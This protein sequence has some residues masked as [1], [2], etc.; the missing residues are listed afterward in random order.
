[1]KVTYILHSS[2]LLETDNCTLLFDYYDGNCPAIRPDKPL[3]VFASH[4]HHDHFSEKVF[5]IPGPD[6]GVH[7]ILSD[8]IEEDEVP[9][10]AGQRD[11]IF[12]GPYRKIEFYKGSDN[13]MLAHRNVEWGEGG[14][15]CGGECTGGAE[16]F[17]SVRTLKSND[18]GVAFI[19]ETDGL[20]IYYAGD[21]NNWWWEG[22]EE[23]RKLADLYHEELRR[24]EGMKFD[25]AFI[26]LDPRIKGY[27]LGIED[28]LGY[29]DARRIFPMHMWGKYGITEQ[30]LGRPEAGDLAEKIVRIEREG[31]EFYVYI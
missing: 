31:Q 6:A 3:F 8:D 28:F 13:S 2:F 17:L 1:M 20:K 10:F 21:L 11:I 16:A 18:L 24:I 12:A 9:G 30:L 26:P 19:I 23:D 14:R 29:C 5:E 4:G 7:Y 25:A 22:D 27:E 15:D